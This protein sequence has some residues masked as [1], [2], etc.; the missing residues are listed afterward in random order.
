MPA[1]VTNGQALNVCFSLFTISSTDPETGVRAI[2]SSRTS[3][4]KLLEL[5]ARMMLPAVAPD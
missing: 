5:M 1:I 4:E 2:A 3:S